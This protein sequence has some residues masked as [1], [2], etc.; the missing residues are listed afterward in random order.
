MKL[1]GVRIERG[2]SSPWVL[3]IQFNS[4]EISEGAG[5]VHLVVRGRRAPIRLKS[6]RDYKILVGVNLQSEPKLHDSHDCLEPDQTQCKAVLVHGS[7][8][9][10]W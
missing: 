5:N 7:P 10:R 2:R 9:H 3:T 4:D 8:V 1:R 6:R